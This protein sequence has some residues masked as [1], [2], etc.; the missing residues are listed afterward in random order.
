[1]FLRIGAAL[2]LLFLVAACASGT[3]AS[4]SSCVPL[5]PG[6]SVCDNVDGVRVSFVDATPTAVLGI[7]RLTQR[8]D[9]LYVFHVSWAKERPLA[10]YAR[11]QARDAARE[12][13]PGLEIIGPVPDEIEGMPAVRY[14]LKPSGVSGPS[15]EARVIVVVDTGAGLALFNGSSTGAAATR[16]ALYSGAK[17]VVKILD[18]RK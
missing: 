9:F 13:G 14:D 1:M 6:L 8:P 7:A 5:N 2:F 3:V 17:T 11:R 12:A 4:R 16:E 10:A 15:S 18:V